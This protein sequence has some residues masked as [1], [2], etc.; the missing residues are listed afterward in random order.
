MFQYI[1][2]SIAGIEIFPI[3]SLFLFFGLFLGIVYWAVRAD[4]D[5]LKK[6]EELPLDVSKNNG[7]QND[8]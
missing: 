4:K 3:V 6:M 5:Y 1:F 2:D 7:E 8:G